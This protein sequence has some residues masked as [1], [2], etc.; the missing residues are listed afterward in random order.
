MDRPEAQIP[1]KPASRTMRADKPL[2]A[3]I[4]NS[5]WSLNSIWRNLALR[6]APALSFA[7]V[8]GARAEAANEAFMTG[9]SL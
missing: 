6:E 7:A 9:F 4:R 1:L 3:S 5:S 2:W 8:R